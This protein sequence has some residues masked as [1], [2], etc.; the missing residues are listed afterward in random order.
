MAKIKIGGAVLTLVALMFL[1]IVIFGGMTYYIYAVKGSVLKT[2]SVNMPTGASVSEQ[3]LILKEQGF[4]KDTSDFCALSRRFKYV[5]ARPGHYTLT[6][7]MTFRGLIGRLRS[8]NQTPVKLT[9]NNIR[10]VERLAGAISK[11]IEADSLTM[12]GTLRNPDMLALYGFGKSDIISM[13]IPDTYQVYWTI[14]PEELM[15]RMNKEYERFWSARGRDD[16]RKKLNLSRKE[17]STLASIVVEESKYAPEQ[18]RIAGVYLNRLRKK[19]PLQADPTVKY[20]LGD[21]SIKRILFKHL[22]VNSPYNTYKHTGLPPGPI[23]CPPISAIDAVLDYEKH[24]YL[25]FCAAPDLSGRHRF[26]TTLTQHNANAREYAKALDKA[27][28]R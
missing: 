24:N 26:A 16:K 12:L 17:V 15:A 8:G 19:M 18:P 14:T 9:F 13:F 22:E 10:T 20:A 7:G 1:G 27:G 21:P 25:Y 2:G 28:I 23:Y 3:A 5:K 6:K 11:C 4:L